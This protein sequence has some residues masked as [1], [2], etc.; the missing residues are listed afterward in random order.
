[1]NFTLLLSLLRMGFVQAIIKR[2]G[3]DA[4]GINGEVERR[5]SGAQEDRRGQ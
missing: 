3:L 1:M 2:H 5:S 4:R